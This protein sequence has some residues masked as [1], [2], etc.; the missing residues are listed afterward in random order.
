MQPFFMLN[1]SVKS[2]TASDE[3]SSEAVFFVMKLSV[4]DRV[5]YTAFAMRIMFI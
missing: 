1:Y 5:G 2:K 4:T 3:N